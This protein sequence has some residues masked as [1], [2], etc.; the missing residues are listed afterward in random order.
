VEFG[1]HDTLAEG[2]VAPH[3]FGRLLVGGR[4]EDDHAEGPVEARAGEHQP[5]LGQEPL[6]R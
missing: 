4:L 6:S 1:G 5:A 2:G 3:E